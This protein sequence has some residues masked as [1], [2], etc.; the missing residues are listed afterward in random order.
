MKDFTL[1]IYSLYL[2][3]IKRNYEEILT[4]KDFLAMDK[5]PNKFCIL[6]HDVD[7]NPLYALKMAK[8]ENRLNISSTYYFRTK[9]NTFDKK[10]IKEIFSLGHEIGY[11][12][13]SLG[14]CKGDFRLAYRDFVRNLESLRS[15]VQIKTVSMHGQPLSK[16]DN[17][18]LWKKSKYHD[19]LTKDLLI[20]GE[21]YLDIDYS[22]IAYLTDAGRNWLS[23]KDN[24]RDHVN[25]NINLNF[26]N[27]SELIK[28]FISSEDN[29]IF[30]THPERWPFSG[31]G[32]L[33]SYLRD[34][35]SNYGK[36]ML[37]QLY[38]DID[39]QQNS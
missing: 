31:S 11:H 37:K 35:I 16:F 19:L 20:L 1:S 23:N 21:I 3:A 32:Y 33:I 8:L 24:L 36:F 38:K 12:Y 28:Y 4:F 7:R 5:K 25:S 6:R 13:E 29:L 30:S 14:D 22:N 17:R 26:H 9:K 18:D 10:I 15:L 34:K 2:K 39:V 27:P